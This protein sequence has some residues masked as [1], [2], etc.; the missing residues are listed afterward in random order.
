MCWAWAGTLLT[1]TFANRRNGSCRFFRRNPHKQPI[2][3][4]KALLRQ[5]M[6]SVDCEKLDPILAFGKPDFILGYLAGNE[7]VSV[8]IGFVRLFSRMNS[9]AGQV[10]E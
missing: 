2:R 1:N 7:T 8:T 9:L 5:T 10:T 4:S 6:I 3:N